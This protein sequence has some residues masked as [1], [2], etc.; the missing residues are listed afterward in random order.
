MPGSS[1]KGVLVLQSCRSDVSDIRF[2]D[3]AAPR[4]GGLPVASDAHVPG[5]SGFTNVLCHR[6]ERFWSSMNKKALGITS[7]VLI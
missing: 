4:G 3:A 1:D 2:E 7:E 6:D 5:P